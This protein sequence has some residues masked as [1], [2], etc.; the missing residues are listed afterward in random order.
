MQGAV[1]R[2]LSSIREKGAISNS[3]VADLLGTRAE[4]VSRWNNGHRDPHPSTEQLLLELEFIIELLSDFYEPKEAR[5]FLY[6]P[7]KLLGGQRPADLIKEGKISEVH[8]L[9]N[10]IRDGVYL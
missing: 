4:T 7:Q 2:R 3:E 10:Q 6:A 9:V 1:A 8:R 5:L